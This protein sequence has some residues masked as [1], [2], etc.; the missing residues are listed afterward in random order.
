MCS[1]NHTPYDSSGLFSV[2]TLS[3]WISKTS[4]IE[5][6]RGQTKAL[7]LDM[8][9][10]ASSSY[11]RSCLCLILAHPLSFS[12]WGWRP[13]GLVFKRRYKPLSFAALLAPDVGFPHYCTFPCHIV[14]ERCY[15]V[16]LFRVNT[17]LLEVHPSGSRR[18]FSPSALLGVAINS[19]LFERGHP[20]CL[21]LLDTSFFTCLFPQWAVSPMRT[22]TISCSS[23]FPYPT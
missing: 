6:L 22:G 16:S 10:T 12:C 17:I 2:L 19:P 9:L 21:P 23:L 15:S 3:S 11:H 7:C 1:M 14:K 8:L 4:L 18:E 5:F 20:E 13:G